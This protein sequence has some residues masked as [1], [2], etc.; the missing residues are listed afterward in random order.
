MEEHLRR[1]AETQWRQA[2]G[3]YRPR[4]RE[5]CCRIQAW[6]Q[7]QWHPTSHCLYSEKSNPWLTKISKRGFCLTSSDEGFLHAAQS[8][9]SRVFS[10]IGLLSFLEVIQFD[11][12]YSLS[13]TAE[14]LQTLTGLYVVF[15]FYHPLSVEMESRHKPVFC[16]S[17]WL[18]MW[19]KKKSGFHIRDFESS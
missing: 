3:A 19:Y 4:Q 18:L 12:W 11:L 14:Q 2:A 15:D 5:S 9:C 16:R 8:C 1:G 13:V 6:I 10:L 17:W 7:G